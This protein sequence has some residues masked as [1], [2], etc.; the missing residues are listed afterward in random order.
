MRIRLRPLFLPLLLVGS[1]AACSQAAPPDTARSGPPH[2]RDA[3]GWGPPPH[4]P[5]D[6][7]PM[8][9]HPGAAGPLG[10]G[11]MGLERVPSAE[12]LATVPGLSAAQQQQLW[13]L[14][15]ARRDALQAQR[16]RD[17]TAREQ[18]EQ[19]SANRIRGLL[20]ED[21]FAR[22]ARWSTQRLGPGGPDLPPAPPP[23]P[24]PPRPGKHLP[25]PAASGSAQLPASADSSADY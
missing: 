3:H 5:M 24:P 6:M 17:Q 11:P 19:D 4:G 13:Q 9:F 10:G 18:I 1:L 12:A 7:P 22:Y 16:Q 25:P 14:L 2:G 15:I 21:E 8:G 23:P 20:G